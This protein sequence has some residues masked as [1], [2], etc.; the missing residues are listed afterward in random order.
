MDIYD[1]TVSSLNLYR[2]SV[3]QEASSVVSVTDQDC[4]EGNTGC[5]SVYGFEYKPGFESDGESEFDWISGRI[6]DEA[7]RWIHHLDQ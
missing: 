2:G 5:F 1:P 6:V 3:Y 4:Y 7:P